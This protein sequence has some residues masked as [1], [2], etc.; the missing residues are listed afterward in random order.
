MELIWS[1]LAVFFPEQQTSVP[2]NNSSQFF[3]FIY[4]VGSMSHRISEVNKVK[5]HEE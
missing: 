4:V 5:R 2:Q 3:E 1:R